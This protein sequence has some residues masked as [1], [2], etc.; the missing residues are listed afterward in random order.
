MIHSKVGESVTV[1]ITMPKVEKPIIDIGEIVKINGY[2][3]IHL[4]VTRVGVGEY[5]MKPI[6]IPSPA[7][8]LRR[9]KKSPFSKI[10][11][12]II[13]NKIQGI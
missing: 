13:K 10:K 9:M 1:T 6:Y 5:T 4:R 2:K 7:S 11:I 12:P 3:R 8:R